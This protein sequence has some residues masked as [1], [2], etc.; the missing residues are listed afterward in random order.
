MSQRRVPILMTAVALVALTAC[1]SSGGGASST[2]SSDAPATTTTVAAG[3]VASSA[4]VSSAPTESS[5][6]TAASTAATSTSAAPTTAATTTAPSANDLRAC[7]QGDWVMKTDTLDLLVATVVPVPGLTVSYGGLRLTFTADEAVYKGAGTL[8]FTR[9]DTV[10][11]LDWDWT[12]RGT[13]QVNEG[14]VLMN[15][16]DRVNN[17][18]EARAGGFSVPGLPTP[19]PPELAGGPATCTPTTLTF[20]TTSTGANTI[21]LVFE[22][23]S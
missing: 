14:L 19:T 10:A 13:Y 4:P 8:R 17:V 23:A 20:A 7:V 18:G 3:E 6:A 22:R 5:A 16:T 9:D 15:Y 12:H 11:E 2:A 1:G 21:V